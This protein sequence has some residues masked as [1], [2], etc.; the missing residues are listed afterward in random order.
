MRAKKQGRV[1]SGRRQADLHGVHR[2]GDGRHDPRSS[3]SPTRRSTA[4]T[5]STS[6][7]S[8]SASPWRSSRADRAGDPNADERNMLGLCRAIQDLAQRARAR[9]SS[10]RR[11]CRAARSR[12]PIPASSARC[13]ACRS[14]ASRRSRFSASAAS[15]SAWSSSNDM[16]AIRPMCYLT[17]GYDHRLI[18]GA[19]AGRFLQALKERLQNFDEIVAVAAPSRRDRRARASA[20]STTQAGARAAEDAR[21]G[22]ARRT[23]RRHAAAARASAGHHAR[24]QDA[25][26]AHATSSRRPSEL[27]RRG[28][29]GHETGR[30]GDVTYHGP[31]QLVGYPIFD[32]DPDRR[33]VHRYV[34]DLEEALI[35]ALSRVRHRRRG[36]CRA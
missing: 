7:T 25:R 21:R 9:S 12:S 24:R 34:R 8:T 5:S 4:R 29:R 22:A 30:G 28:R 13:S 36:A 14:S 15:T 17:L 35:I 27:A 16:I 1:R 3:R 26:R 11:K 2:E 23:H 20:A 6:A 33:D 32:L 18:D 10:S 31:G 19:D